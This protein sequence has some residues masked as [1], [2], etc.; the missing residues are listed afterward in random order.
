MGNKL[1]EEFIIF[2]RKYGVIGLAVGFITATAATDFVNAL[3]KGL[4]KPLVEQI[5]DLL[6]RGT[7]D[8]LN[9]GFNGSTFGFGD[10]ISAFI[11]FVAVMLVV[12]LLVKFALSKVMTEE[13]KKKV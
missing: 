9:F 7:F 6:G 2:I 3:S 13:E 11:N 10:I 12:F 1:V 5:V 8:R 4:L